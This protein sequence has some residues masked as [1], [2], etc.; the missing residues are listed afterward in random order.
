VD[1]PIRNLVY[2]GDAGHI[3]TV[4]VD[5]HIVVVEGRIP[6]LDERKLM[7]AATAAYLWQRDRIAGQHRDPAL[8][9]TLFPTAYPEV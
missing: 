1:D 4:F 7:E 5:G 2:A 3:R 8:A 9:A 6:G